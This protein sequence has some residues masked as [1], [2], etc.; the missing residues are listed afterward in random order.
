MSQEEYY[1]LEK[2]SDAG[3][4]N[5]GLPVFQAIALH[6]VNKLDNIQLE[7]NLPGKKNKSIRINLS[8]NNQVTIDM[9]VVVDYGVAVTSLVNELQKNILASIYEMIRIK[10]C[11]VNIIV[12]S[13]KF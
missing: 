5:I 11:K 10:N 2:K 12:K 8:E 7:G 9:D 13:V 1:L 4:L 3:N 6:A